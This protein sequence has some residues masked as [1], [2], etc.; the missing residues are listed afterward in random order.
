M[1]NKSKPA[2]S[3]KNDQ[4]FPRVVGVSIAGAVVVMLGLVVAIGVNAWW[5]KNPPQQA[6]GN[7]N[8]NQV[9]Q[10]TPGSPTT[11]QAPDAPS[12]ANG[13][14]RRTPQPETNTAS[15][16]ETN[17]VSGN[18]DDDDS[19]RTTKTKYVAPAAEAKESKEAS[20]SEIAVY[21]SGTPFEDR[22]SGD[23][24]L[25]GLTVTTMD[26]QAGIALRSVQA[27]YVTPGGTT[28]SRVYGTVT[29]S[30]RTVMARDGYAI[31]GI[32]GHADMQNDNGVVSGF[33]V[34]FMRSRGAEL[35]S[36]DSYESRWLG[37]LSRETNTKVFADGK[38]AVGIKGRQRSGNIL[39]LGLIFAGETAENI[40]KPAPPVWPTSPLAQEK[41]PFVVA[42]AEADEISQHAGFTLTK[43]AETTRLFRDGILTAPEVHSG[44]V[45]FKV[46]A[47][48]PGVGWYN[49]VYRYRDSRLRLLFDSRENRPKT[50]SEGQ[51]IR[52]VTLDEGAVYYHTGGQS[53]LCKWSEVEDAHSVIA[54]Y[55]VAL[56]G[57]SLTL[58]DFGERFSV[59]RGVVAFRGTFRQATTKGTT[60]GIYTIADKQI[61]RV[62]DGTTPLSGGS[63]M[64]Q[65]FES[66]M[67]RGNDVVFHG[68]RGRQSGIYVVTGDAVTIIADSRTKSPGSGFV[69]E[70]FSN[71]VSIHDGRV[72]FIAV[73]PKAKKTGVF[74]WDR[75][76]PDDLILVADDSTPLPHL[77]TQTF[78]AFSEVAVGDNGVAF[79]AKFGRYYGI[80]YWSADT[81]KIIRVMSAYQV[82]DD[83]SPMRYKLSPD[84]MHGNKLAFATMFHE[85]TEAIYL[86]T[87]VAN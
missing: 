32:V 33:R 23:A 78:S 48:L 60:Q 77:P 35:D 7:A 85:Q 13:A 58:D 36:T 57:A 76:S 70:R 31:G 65:K 66:P 55:G 28:T 19:K 17:K 49:G 18:A 68:Q 41:A 30:E 6:D 87:F 10:Q 1:H 22:P 38:R 29:D 80:Y 71:V 64:L 83:R 81:R 4:G 84:G 39:A 46:S 56:P 51:T 24:T 11:S 9:A 44:V 5:P 43:I 50:V 72:A 2:A 15:Q 12:N 40:E 25:V 73:S 59:D 34:L 62:M 67:I 26:W 21:T 74:L 75:K 86:A 45:L 54:E 16:P 8:G 79:H 20:A 47:H 37:G 82:I 63:T 3:A 27:H 61:R 69:F 52:A 53:K 42:A 14:A